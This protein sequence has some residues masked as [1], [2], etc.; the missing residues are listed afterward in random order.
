MTICNWWESGILAAC[1]SWI[2]PGEGSSW[3]LVATFLPAPCNSRNKGCPDRLIHGLDKH[4][5]RFSLQVGREVPI[6]VRGYATDRLFGPRLY[7]AH[8]C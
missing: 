4:L 8:V 7:L 3:R 6:D 2:L 5:C 1:G